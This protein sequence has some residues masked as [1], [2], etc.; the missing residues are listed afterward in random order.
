MSLHHVSLT[1]VDHLRELLRVYDFQQEYDAQQ[2]LA[3]QRL[4][5]GILSV[6]SSF[7]ERM[8]RGSPIRGIQVSVELDEDHFAGPGDA[9]LFASI[10]DRFMGLYV[11]VNAFSQ[12]TVRFSRSGQVY[13]FLPRWGDRMTPAESRESE[14]VHA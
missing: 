7:R 2:A 13:V 9:Y 6:R 1:S 5:E 10:L 8:V 12:T 14:A 3:H 11:T 4:L